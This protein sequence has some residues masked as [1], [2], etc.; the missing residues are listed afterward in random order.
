MDTTKVHNLALAGLELDGLKTVGDFRRNIRAQIYRRWADVDN[1]AQFIIGM[2]G[3]IDRG[4]NQ[5]WAQGA[6]VCGVKMDELT[7]AERDAL[8]Q[9]INDQFPYITQFGVYIALNTKELG[10]KRGPLYDRAELWVARYGE[11]VNQAKALACKDQK[12]IW[13]LGPTEHCG[14]CIRLSGRVK[15]G[16]YWTEKGILPRRAGAGYLDCGGYNCQCS[17]DPTTAPITPGPLPR[18]P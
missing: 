11:I 12:L 3:S 5:A 1:D 15:R 8:Q 18:L 14:S 7:N 10:G 16:S 6:A 4:F 2:N 9:R 17:L 13:N